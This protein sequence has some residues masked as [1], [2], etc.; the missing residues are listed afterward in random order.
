[1]LAIFFPLR[2]CTYFPSGEIKT[3]FS[4]GTL[5][6]YTITIFWKIDRQGRDFIIKWTFI[7][8]LQLSVQV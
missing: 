4:F 8:F 6:I 7:N 2:E 3:N 1:M 5:E